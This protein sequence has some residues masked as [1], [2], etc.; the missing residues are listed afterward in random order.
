MKSNRPILRLLMA[1]IP[2]LS[3]SLSIP[4]WSIDHEGIQERI[5]Q[6]ADD[7]DPRVRFQAALTLGE[8]DLPGRIEALAGIARKDAAD[9]WVRRA[10]LSSIGSD[11]VEFLEILIPEVGDS[12]EGIDSLI[13]ELSKLVGTKGQTEDIRRLLAAIGQPSVKEPVQVLVLNGLSE[14]LELFG[15]MVAN[16]GELAA[17]LADLLVNPSEKIRGVAVEIASKALP[18]DSPELDTLISEQ[19]ARLENREGENLSQSAK[20]LR[21]GSYDRVSGALSELLTSQSHEALQVAALE[22]LSTYDHPG[23]GKTIIDHW[24]QLAPKAKIQ[25]LDILMARQDRAMQLLVAI[26]SEEMPG[27]ILDSQRQTLLLGYPDSAVADKAKQIFSTL[28]TDE[29]PELYNQYAEAVTLEGDREKGK[30]IYL[31]RCTQCHIAEGQGQQLGPDW[32]GLKSNTR[33]TLLTSILYPNRSVDPG[34]TNYILETVDGDIFTGVLAFSGPNS[35]VLRRGGA[36]E[37]TILRKNIEYLEDT[38]KS[39]MPTNLEVGLSPQDMAD[40]LSFIETLK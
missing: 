17:P 35:V 5:L 19:I 1:A 14:G 12:T 25:A 39:I 28:S 23:V 9:P 40:L 16:G 32:S 34:F 3:M 22:T 7:P 27:N 24:S 13:E 2:M 29:D 38:K 11:T 33:E 26:E 4:S 18:Q 10:I 30:K 6:L 15:G 36:E 37:D 8:V 21:L 20:M 31:E